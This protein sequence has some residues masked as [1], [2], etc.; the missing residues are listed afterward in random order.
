MTFFVFFFISVKFKWRTLY[1]ICSVETAPPCITTELQ[2]TLHYSHM[3]MY[4]YHKCFRVEIYY[5]ICLQIQI[6]VSS[7]LAHN[8]DS[9]VEYSGSYG[10]YFSASNIVSASLANNGGGSSLLGG[11][12]RHLVDIFIIFFPG[13]L[14][15]NKPVQ[16]KWAVK[17]AGRLDSLQKNLVS[18]FNIYY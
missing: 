1:N 16:I 7:S 4:I 10:G 17:W 5:C 14:G 9:G 11:N 18:N 2:H 6:I 8:G 12:Q 3:Y 15:Q 13:W